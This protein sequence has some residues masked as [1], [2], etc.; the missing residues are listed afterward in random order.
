MTQ[1]NSGNSV[2][3][4]A[5]LALIVFG[6]ALGLFLR[7][8]EVKADRGPEFTKI[9]LEFADYIGDERR[10]SEPT[11]DILKADTTTLRR[12]RDSAGN[13]YWLFIA[14][15]KEQKY[16]SQIHSPRQCLP[17]GGWRID[18]IDPYSLALSAGLTQ[19]VNL[20]TI[21]RQAAKQI[22]FY[23][24]ETRSGSIRGEFALKFDL[25][26][27]ALLFRPTDA[28][29]VRLTVQNADGDIKS[30]KELGARFLRELET[31]LKTALP[32][33]SESS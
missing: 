20:L 31:S 26:K 3:P 30:A 29:F 28:G 15:F 27:N 18:S 14:Y 5:P 22:M 12:Y 7:Y 17:G 23:W 1:S 33:S 6:G 16:G 9:P 21:E 10:F 24:F 11:Y 32:F 13:T 2:F 8:Y 25:V 4:W 19:P